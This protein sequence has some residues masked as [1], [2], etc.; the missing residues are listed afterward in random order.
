MPY[1]IFRD[2]NSA[3]NVLSSEEALRGIQIS[4]FAEIKKETQKSI[5]SSYKR[6]LRDLE[7]DGST[8][9]FDKFAAMAKAAS[10]VKNG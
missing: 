5:V 9:N 6:D 4:S 7:S 8:P 1:T 10:G 2:Y 3:I